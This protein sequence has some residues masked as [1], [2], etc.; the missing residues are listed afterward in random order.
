VEHYLGACAG[1]DA[2]T[3]VSVTTTSGQTINSLDG[4]DSVL[5]VLSNGDQHDG[6]VVSDVSINGDSVTVTYVPPS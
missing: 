5:L 4:A 3:G 1:A 6:A 2:E